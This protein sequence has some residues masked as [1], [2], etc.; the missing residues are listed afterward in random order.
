MPKNFISLGEKNS[1]SSKTEIGK[2]SKDFTFGDDK[3]LENKGNLSKSSNN[4]EIL[5]QKEANRMKLLAFDTLTKVIGQDSQ[6]N[7]SNFKQ[8]SVTKL[9]TFNANNF[10]KKNNNLKKMNETS[11][12]IKLDV[13]ELDRGNRGVYYSQILMAKF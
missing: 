2:P 12:L 7:E 9:G 8:M 13:R 11:K 4:M 1:N 3:L 5:K 10:E 6:K